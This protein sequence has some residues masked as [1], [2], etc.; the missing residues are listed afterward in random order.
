MMV[1]RTPSSRPGFA[2][3]VDDDSYFSSIQ[4]ASAQEAVPQ[5]QEQ[6]QEQEAVPQEQEQE[7]EQEAVPQEQEPATTNEIAAA[8]GPLIDFESISANK[9]GTPE[10]GIVSTQYGDS[11]ITFNNAVPLDYSDSP[12]FAHSGTKAIE[13]CYSKEFCTTPFEMTFTT[14]QKHIKVWVGY[15]GNLAETRTVVLRAFDA[16]GTEVSQATATLQSNSASSQSISTP[17]EVITE[18]PSI[19][20]ATVSFSPDTVLMN[21]LALDDIEFDTAGPSPACASTRNPTVTLTQPANGFS[22]QRN[23]F[24]LQGAVNTQ[25]PLQKATLTVI[26]TGS[27]DT[28][29]TTEAPQERSLNL[30]DSLISPEELGNFGIGPT[31]INELLFPGSNIISVTVQDCHGSTES[32]KITVSF[33]PISTDDTRFVFLG[34]DAN[35][36]QSG[37]FDPDK[38][39]PPGTLTAGKKTSVRVYLSLTSEST[40]EIRNVNGFLSASYPGPKGFGS[41]DLGESLPPGR[42]LSKNTITVDQSTDINAKRGDM[43]ATLNFELPSEWIKPGTL[44]LSFTPLI[45]GE[46]TNLPC[47]D[48]KLQS[49]PGLKGTGCDNFRANGRPAFISF[50]LPPTRCAQWLTIDGKNIIIALDPDELGWAHVISNKSQVVE[51]EIVKSEVNYQEYPFNHYSHD[52]NFYV[53]LDPI[54]DAYKA[55][56]N[57]VVEGEQV[58]EM[59]WETANFPPEFWPMKGDRVW[60][61]GRYVWDCEHIYDKGLRTEIHPPEAVAFT[62]QEPVVF[63]VDG[64]KDP[65]PSLASKTYIYIHGYGGY[66]NAAVGG[67]NYEF[68]IALPPKPSPT[69]ELYTEVLEVPFGDVRPILTQIGT[70]E[71]PKVHVVYPLLSSVPA[72]PDKKFGAVVAAGWREQTPSQR[73]HELDVTFNSIVVRDDEDYFSEGEWKVWASVNGKW[74]ELVGGPIE[75]TQ[76]H[77]DFDSFW[78]DDKL[79]LQHKTV[80]V[81]VPDNG[82]LT[83]STTGWESDSADDFFGK[84]QAYGGLFLTAIDNNNPIDNFLKEYTKANNFNIGTHDIA[85]PN[86]ADFSLSVTIT[87]GTPPPGGTV[88]E[89]ELET[90]PE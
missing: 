88:L 15:R 47:D 48:P 75:D 26:G 82:K 66:Y 19:I 24:I 40:K 37:A 33:A 79:N 5:E 9:P 6:E 13:Q 14:A 77:Q 58:M 81:T 51:G 64:V 41:L 46:D 86:D 52:Q 27:I 56:A 60:M 45:E 42:L 87:E 3:V 70:Q 78:S 22:T 20:R 12:D 62:R 67:K 43:A 29:T 18:T 55:P 76:N 50:L 28:T 83:I 10:A 63:T 80:H 68:D 65:L 7:Q 31:R 30:F 39:Y 11:G 54:Y 49:Y 84:T 38:D 36:Q 71:N 72:S 89:R 85:S 16:G 57:E 8:T 44:H 69:A 17:L 74:I 21:N 59:E 35:Q 25:A 1:I 34:M 32:D 90:L 73:Y 2:H 53:K 4:Q 23:E 61:M